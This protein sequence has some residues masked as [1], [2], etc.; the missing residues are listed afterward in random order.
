[1]GQ[2]NLGET[3]LPKILNSLKVNYGFIILLSVVL[4][5]FE[6]C[7]NEKL[8]EKENVANS[9]LLKANFFMK[10]WENFL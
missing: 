7:H 8:G 9:Y 3:R 6:N 10:I 5:K 2:T 1:M 4:C